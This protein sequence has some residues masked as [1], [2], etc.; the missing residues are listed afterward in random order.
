MDF[1]QKSNFFLFAFFTEILSENNVFDIVEKKRM[2]L[3]GKN[4]SFKKGHKKD[5]FERGW[6]M[7][8]SKTHNFYYRCFFTEIMS[9]KIVFG[10]L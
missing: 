1:V 9:Q 8:L 3:S 7:T 5:I 6:S 4:S 2:I 10:Y